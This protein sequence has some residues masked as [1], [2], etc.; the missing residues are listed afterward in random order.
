MSREVFTIKN[1]FF[2]D[3]DIDH[4]NDFKEFLESNYA[5]N[6]YP[7]D[8]IDFLKKIKPITHYET[9][10][11]TEIKEAQ[12]FLKSLSISLD[13]DFFLIDK[14]L[15]AKKMPTIDLAERIKNIISRDY[16]YYKITGNIFGR[17]DDE[18][19]KPSNDKYDHNFVD[20]L[21]VNLNG[22]YS[23]YNLK[24]KLNEKT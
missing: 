9:Y 19:I 7:D 13:I 2:I 24:F 10:E 8:I 5:V 1:L 22:Y 20:N 21:L 15:D 16:F 14:Q 23:D 17:S 11:V 3:N 18:I 4:F 12:L 6:V